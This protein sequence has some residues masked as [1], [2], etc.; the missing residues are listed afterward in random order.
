[1]KLWVGSA[2]S[3]H[4]EPYGVIACIAE[5]KGE[6]IAKIR[7]EIERDPSTHPRLRQMERDIL[8]H[9]DVEVEEVGEQVFIDWSPATSSRP[10]WRTASSV[11]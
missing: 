8:D 6:A 2:M 5:S 9:L 3:R 11:N 7:N 4:G 10:S 1:M